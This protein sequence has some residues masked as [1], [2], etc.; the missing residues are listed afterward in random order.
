MQYQR[1]KDNSTIKVG[2]INIPL[3]IMNRTIRQKSTRK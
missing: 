3:A 2:D 1:E